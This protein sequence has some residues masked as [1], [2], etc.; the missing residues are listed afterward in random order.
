MNLKIDHVQLAAPAGC[1]ADAR[2]FFGTIL[3]LTERP[4][5]GGPVKRGGVWFVVAGQE[6]HVGVEAGFAPA[7]K[8]HVAFRMEALERLRVLATRLEERDYP[9]KW[10]DGLPGIRRFFTTDP[11]GNRLEFLADDPSKVD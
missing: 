5:V 9:V 8:A 1:E 7:R 6:I 4:K 2:A 11:W 3:G 10:N